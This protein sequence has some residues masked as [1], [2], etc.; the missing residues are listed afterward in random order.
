MLRR[1]SRTMAYSSI[2]KATPKLSNLLPTLTIAA[3]FEDSN[4][5]GY[6]TNRILRHFVRE[7]VKIELFP[8]FGHNP[9]G[10][11]MPF[12]SQRKPRS[13]YDIVFTAVANNPEG[14]HGRLLFTMY[15]ATEVPVQY[16]VGLRRYDQIVVPTKFSADAIQPWTKRKIKL[17][18]LGVS[19]RWAPPL[20]QPFTFTAVATDH[21]CPERKRI[22]ELT[23]CFSE[24]FKHE[25]DVRLQL[26][27]T[28]ECQKIR[29]FDRRV[30]IVD[31]RLERSTYERLIHTT[32]VGV[33]VSAMEGWSLPVNE[34]M[35]A[36]RPVITPLAG[37]MGDYCNVN[38]CF[39][40]RTTLVSAPR[41]IFLGAGK[42]P[43]ADMKHL[44]TQLR[45]VYENRQ[46][47]VRRGL[48]AY[49]HA[50]RFTNETMG[51]NFLR[52]CQSILT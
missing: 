16:G 15:E 50:Q 25:G 20:F 30:E 11:L 12:V 46:D 23:D 40:V 49:D 10:D 8:L 43:W 3:S 45:F 4:G 14:L 17:C 47:V 22:Q 9:P 18:P 51:Q 44:S 2:H 36:G 26:K 42:I 52:L 39:P 19:M 38:C 7:G 29:T 32:T 33:Q 41:N 1:N 13:K 48:A 27:R 21:Q 24:T 35:A 34:F 28:P 31:T 6:F 37:A 5:Y